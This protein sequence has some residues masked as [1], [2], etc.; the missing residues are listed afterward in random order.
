MLVRQERIALRTAVAVRKTKK[1][2]RVHRKSEGRLCSMKK[3]LS[4]ALT[5]AMLFSLAATQVAFAAEPDENAGFVATMAENGEDIRPYGSLSG[6]TTYRVNASSSSRV[7]G[8][9]QVDVGGIPWF[10]AQV[11]FTASGFNSDTWINCELYKPDGTYVWGIVA[12]GGEYLTA[13]GQ[14]YKQF[15]GG[16]TGLYTVKY[17]VKTW[18]GTPVPTGTITCSI[19]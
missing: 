3:F 14:A 7:T 4:L 10:T 15:S 1:L 6:S 19:Y 17:E 13:G 5:L 18:N 2:E 11:K 9:F 8:S 16:S 12:Q